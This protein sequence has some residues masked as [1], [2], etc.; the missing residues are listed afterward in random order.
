MVK[1]PTISLNKEMLFF[2]ATYHKLDRLRVALTLIR[3][4]ARIWFELL[5]L[6]PEYR[7]AKHQ[8]HGLSIICAVDE[9]TEWQSIGD[10]QPD[11]KR[12]IAFANEAPTEPLRHPHYLTVNHCDS[13]SEMLR[14]FAPPY[15]PVVSDE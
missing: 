5:K 13:L 14:F 7:E 6:E 12:D 3:F 9:N 15:W 11:D 4:A 8:T 2:T 10:A 1:K